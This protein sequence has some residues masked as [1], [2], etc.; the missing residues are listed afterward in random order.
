[1]IKKLIII[2]ILVF[3]FGWIAGNAYSQ[4]STNYVKQPFSV[5]KSERISP[6][7]HISQD[8]IFVYD[9]K[10]VINIDNPAW[11]QFTDTNSMDPVIDIGSNSIE[12]K[13]RTP[14]DVHIGDIVSYKSKLIEGVII[15]RVVAIN[16][17]AEGF[18]YTL[19]GD[20]NLISD[21][22]KVRFD[23]VEGVVVGVIY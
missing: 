7:D 23:Q 13:P 20:N 4:Q 21:P 10:V 5:I 11:A 22:E 8:N 14:E 1:M 3:L 15:H 18:Y 2:T 6:F 16:E 9:D 17:D 19:K 12:I